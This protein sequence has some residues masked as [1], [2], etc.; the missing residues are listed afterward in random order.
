VVTLEG[1]PGDSVVKFRH[2]K[3]PMYEVGPFDVSH[4]QV[5]GEL[6]VETSDEIDW[7]EV[8]KAAGDAG[9][10]AKE[11][12]VRM[13][14]KL[15][16]TKAE[17]DKARRRLNKTKGVASFLIPPSRRDVSGH[18]PPTV[19]QAEPGRPLGRSRSRDHVPGSLQKDAGPMNRLWAT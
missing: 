12:A 5:R 2:L 14:G 19:D 1:E 3:Q 4:D 8:V 11:A 10:T 9:I 17:V 7:L 18:T 16:P 13:T 15:T 6:T